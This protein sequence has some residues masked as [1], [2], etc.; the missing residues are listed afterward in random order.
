MGH[1]LVE[2]FITDRLLPRALSTFIHF[3]VIL[4]EEEANDIV[5]DIINEYSNYKRTALRLY[6]SGR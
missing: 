3:Y 1:G 5:K 4:K 6:T 2:I